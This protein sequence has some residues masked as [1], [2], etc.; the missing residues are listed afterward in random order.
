MVVQHSGG[1][2]GTHRLVDDGHAGATLADVRRQ[3]R[4][5]GSVWQR[6][7]VQRLQDAVTAVLPDM[8]EVRAP[9]EFLHKP[10][11]DGQPVPRCHVR[12]HVG[13]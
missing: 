12:Q 6:P 5:V 9:A 11:L 8:A 13:R 2:Q 3:F 4:G 7:V 10:V 1:V